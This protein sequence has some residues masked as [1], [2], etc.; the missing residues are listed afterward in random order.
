MTQHVILEKLKEQINERKV[1]AAV[2]YTFTFNAEFFEN[3]FLPLFIPNVPFSNDKIQNAILWRQYEPKLPPL[4]VYCD[5]HEKSATAPTLGYTVRTIDMPRV[6]GIKPCFH[7][8]ISLILLEDNSLIVISGSNNLTETGWFTNKEIISIE[9]LKNDV[10]MPWSYKNSLKTF[11]NG[12][13]KL[14]GV[15]ES[16]ESENK[17]KSFLK[18]QLYTDGENIDFYNPFDSNFEKLL[19]NLKKNGNNDTEFETI[20]IIS[21]YLT[22]ST[23][24]IK[25]TSE[26][27]RDNKFYL[28]TPYGFTNEADISEKNYQEFDKAG[29]IWSKFKIP[30]EEKYF[31]FSHAKVYRLKGC[32]RFFTIVG[33]ANFTKA[34]WKGFNKGGNIETAVI[35]S[36]PVENWDSWLIPD[37]NPDIKFVEK[38]NSEKNPDDRKDVPN[39]TFKLDWYAKTLTYCLKATG[40]FHGRILFEEKTWKSLKKGSETISL[41]ENRLAILSLDPSIK[42]SYNNNI[43]FFYPDQI[44]LESKPLSIKLKLNDIQLLELWN[45]FS[46]KEKENFQ[47]AD[48]IE[49]YIRKKTDKEGEIV[50]DIIERKSTINFMA[51]HLSALINLE[52]KIF[53]V[54]KLKNEYPVAVEGLNYYLFTDNIDTLTGY[55]RMLKEM[56]EKQEINSGF[57]WFLLQILLSD[58]YD[59]G[60]IRRQYK[61]IRGNVDKPRK[62]YSK[63]EKE[64]KKEL[65]KLKKELKTQDLSD[66]DMKWLKGQL[67]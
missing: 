32:S 53:W 16:S 21:P 44:G 39:I 5:F 54:P 22:L 64:I 43:F 48:L 4:T 40:D 13:F 38:A 25:K 45:K 19:N 28:T 8:K 36:E 52:K 27:T 24:L 14:S 55:R 29:V 35:Y 59:W 58:F 10:K 7:P 49:E 2:F 6:S 47:V 51:S 57:Y 50:E 42:I 23:D 65:T 18:K 62:G 12:A 11:F 34:A 20:E 46:V 17:I 30:D 66:K 31:R 1:I 3:H 9:E 41:N 37:H 33:S 67:K 26:F 63:I 56:H 15:G 60:K 61:T